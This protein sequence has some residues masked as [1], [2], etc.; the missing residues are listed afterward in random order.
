M[1]SS[2]IRFSN[3]FSDYQKSQKI[4]AEVY[5]TIRTVLLLSKYKFRQRVELRTD[6]D[7]TITSKL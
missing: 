3:I 4:Q 5:L 7:S 6:Q 1:K 2:R